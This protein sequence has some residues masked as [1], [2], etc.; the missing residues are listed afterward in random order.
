MT[1]V[2]IP[3]P[4]ARTSAKS[5]SKTG[6]VAG[7]AASLATTL[8]AAVAGPLEI[9]G[10]AIPTVGFAQMTMLG[11]VIGTVLAVV[12]ARRARRPQRTFVVTT[13]AL[14]ALSILPDVLADATS[15]TRFVL[16]LTH[17]IAAAI[18]IPALAHKLSQ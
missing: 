8:V 14:T 3:S 6:L 11:S 1:A 18:V 2:T 4:T 17:V 9:A 16:A 5:L 13:V 15:S 7:A 10:E 12:L